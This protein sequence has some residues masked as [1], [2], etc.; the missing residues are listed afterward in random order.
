[1]CPFHI[2][3]W[4][5]L[6]GQCLHAVATC[7]SPAALFAPSY[8]RPDCWAAVP[9]QRQAKQSQQSAVPS[10]C[11]LLHTTARAASTPADTQSEPRALVSATSEAEDVEPRRPAR[12]QHHSAASQESDQCGNEADRDAGAQVTE[13]SRVVLYKG[14]YMQAFRMLVRFKIFQLVGIAALAVPINTFLAGVSLFICCH[15][16]PPPQPPTP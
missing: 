4:S 15:S 9:V 16:P 7:V 14:R 2:A 1:M 13:G 5:Q 6:Q 11:A 10:C 3:D 12:L 8:F